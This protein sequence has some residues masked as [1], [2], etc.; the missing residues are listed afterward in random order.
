MTDV[1]EHL[2]RELQRTRPDYVAY[3][4]EH[5]DGTTTDGLNEHFLVFDDEQ[6][7]SGRSAAGND[8]TGIMSPVLATSG[9]G[10]TADSLRATRGQAPRRPRTLR[11]PRREL[12]RWILKLI[13]KRTA[14]A[15]PS[16]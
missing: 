9:D 6:G 1:G 7:G 2:R 3:V 8:A 13:R 16:E 14:G 11:T 4:P 10:R 5:Y 15:Q 12:C